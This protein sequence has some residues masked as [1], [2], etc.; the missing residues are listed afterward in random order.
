M[1][2]DGVLNTYVGNYDENFIPPIKNG[3][4][5]FLST[6]SK[7]Y[8]IKIFTSRNIESASK[9]VEQNNLSALI[10]GIT[11]IKEPCYLFVDDRCINFNGNYSDLYNEIENFHVW[12]K[13]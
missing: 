11:N 12:F 7:K 3:A 8:K 6:L 2:L 13:K 5:E 4:F 10:D 1:D 9:W